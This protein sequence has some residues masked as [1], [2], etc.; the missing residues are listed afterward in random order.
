MRAVAPLA[1]L[2]L[3]GVLGS[4][5]GDAESDDL[6]VTAEALLVDLD[7]EVDGGPRIT[8]SKGVEYVTATASFP[9]EGDGAV[10][11]LIDLLSDAGWTVATSVALDVSD[12]PAS[13]GHQVVAGRSDDV[14][15]VL[16]Y[17]RIGTR[18]APAGAVWLQLAV[19]EP[20]EALAWTQLD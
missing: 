8:E 13:W 6:L 4:C 7:A 17:D 16:L 12:T 2:V 5:A 19:A 10:G 15:R 1:L 3:V 20:D 9:G 11:E 14:V 18:D